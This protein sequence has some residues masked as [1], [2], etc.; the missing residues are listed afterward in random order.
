MTQTENVPYFV[1]NGDHS[2]RAYFT[3]GAEAR[4]YASWQR[5][6]GRNVVVQ[7]SSACPHLN[8][9]FIAMTQDS[10]ADLRQSILSLAGPV[11]GQGFAAA[12]DFVFR[13]GIPSRP[14]VETGC[15]RGRE[16]EGVSTLLLALTARSVGAKL[17]SIDLNAG[18]IEKARR[19]VEPVG[20]RVQFMCSDSVRALS[21][22]K[23]EPILLYLDA[24]DHDPQNPRPCQE[25][26]LQ[27]IQ[28]IHARLRPPC[29]VL[30]D[31]NVSATGGK[32]RLSAE[33][34]ENNGWH[35]AVNSYQ[36]LFTKE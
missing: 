34:L 10:A 5:T 7:R 22:I 21:E 2:L 9:V 17:I 25:Y 3:D 23:H 15:Y 6:L 27:E 32:S 31:D 14:I 16:W 29:A 11:R 1:F 36:L 12:F 18:H 24:F 30:L 19:L 35:K 13:H 4:E 8:R 28:A 33:F 26:Q 20:E